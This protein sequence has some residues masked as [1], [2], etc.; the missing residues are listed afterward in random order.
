MAPRR[1]WPADEAHEALAW[2]AAHATDRGEL[3]EQAQDHLLA[4]ERYDEW[5]EQWGP[6]PCPLLWSHAM[7]LTLGDRLGTARV[8]LGTGRRQ[9]GRFA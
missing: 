5:V 4:P 6:P 2:V 3:P 1:R 8:E 7:F 9:G